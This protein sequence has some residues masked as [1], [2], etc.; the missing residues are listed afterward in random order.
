MHHIGRQSVRFT[1]PHL[2]SKMQ[3]KPV[4]ACV[5]LLAGSLTALGTTAQAAPARENAS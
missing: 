4:L 5:G 2:E 3:L 1:P